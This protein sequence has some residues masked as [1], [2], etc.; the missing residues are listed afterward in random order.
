M[1]GAPQRSLSSVGASGKWLQPVWMGK[2]SQP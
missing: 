2:V 1:P